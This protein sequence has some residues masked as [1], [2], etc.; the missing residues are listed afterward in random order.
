MIDPVVDPDLTAFASA[1]LAVEREPERALEIE[2]GAGDATLFLAREFPHARIRGLDP[3]E[4]AVAAAAARV[5]LD[6]EGRIAF[7][8]GAAAELPFP[9]GHFDLVA[10]RSGPL[11]PRELVRVLRPGGWLI[12]AAGARARGPLGFSRAAA[13]ALARRGFLPAAGNGPAAEGKFLVMRLAAGE[14]GGAPE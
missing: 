2:C 7:K 4:R 11:S 14:G 9:D 10:Q 5:G 1:L 12:V 6:P 13:V 8:R 3:S